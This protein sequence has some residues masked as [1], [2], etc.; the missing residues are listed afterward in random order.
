M[1]VKVSMLRSMSLS[2]LFSF[3]FGGHLVQAKTAET[4]KTKDGTQLKVETIVDGL[5]HPWGMAFLPDG[6]LLVT[7]KSTG[8]L[9]FL[10]KDKKISKA[11][12]GTPEVFARGQGGLM[13]VAIDPNFKD[14][15]LVYLAYAKPGEDGKAGTALGR[16]RLSG[17]KIE[18]FT[19]IFV[20]KPFIDGTAHFGTRIA[21]SPDGQHLYLAMGERFQ[22][23]PAQDLKSHLGKV[24]RIFPD[25]KIPQ[26]N[27]FVGNKAAE[28]AI[29][30][31]GHRNVESMAFQPGTNALWVVEMG[32]KGGD[33][34]NLIE[35]G[36]NYGW[37]V[38]S[39]GNN[40]DGTKIPDPP[41]HPQFKDAVK[42]W[43]PVIS[44]SGLEFYEGDLFPQWKGHA[45]IG[46]LSSKSLTRL[47][48]DGT[49][50]KE[51]ERLTLPARIR[52]VEEAPDGSIYM[53]TDEAD[54]KIWRM[55][56][57]EGTKKLSRSESTP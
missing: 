25:G 30:S 23:Q 7:E 13:D 21:F 8:K 2:L 41:T 33:E 31:Y 44:P 4:L 1:E 6:R 32:P 35:K 18:G 17:S 45:F 28:D 19:D 54:G 29:W 49:K 57:K 46:G 39:W 14:N 12:E 11:I 9:Y 40:Y 15:G 5:K 26:D 34:L 20:Q 22:F 51:E 53:L 16:G 47:A 36:A 43:N 56:P 10:T 24:V 3:T 37:P 48:F 27:P 55:T 38:V 42:H 50:V 52:D